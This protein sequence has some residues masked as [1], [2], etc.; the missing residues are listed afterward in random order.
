MLY[1]SQSSESVWVSGV[2]QNQGGISW[3]SCNI[4]PIVEASL[5]AGKGMHAE[6][7]ELEYQ[8]TA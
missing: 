1:A 6:I 8:K 3:I 4:V 7:Q 5:L 2:R